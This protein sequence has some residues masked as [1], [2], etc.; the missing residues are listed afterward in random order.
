MNAQPHIAE[1]LRFYY[2]DGKA[3]YEVPGSKPGVMVKP[4]LRHAKKLGLLPSVTSVMRI[5]AKPALESWKREQATLSALTLGRVEG[6]S[7]KD[8]LARVRED[9]NAQAMARAAEGTALHKAFEQ[10]CMGE[11]PEERFL[12]HCAEV[13]KCIV[14]FPANFIADVKTKE[15]IGDVEAKRLVYDEHVMQLAAYAHATPMQSHVGHYGERKLEVETSMVGKQYAGRRDLASYDATSDA[16]LISIFVGVDDAKVMTYI[17]TP[18]EA[19]RGWQMFQS[20]LKLFYL[21]NRMVGVPD[22]SIPQ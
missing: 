15:A 11:Y 8:F 9:A 2:P 4:D 22:A 1:S 12:D 19:E 10:W 20:C 21:A 3:A 13:G 5:M 16:S 6:E 17:W 18:D 14:H 7:D